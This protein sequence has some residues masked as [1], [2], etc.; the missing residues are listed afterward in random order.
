MSSLS[1]VVFLGACLIVAAFQ[2]AA[3][4]DGPQIVEVDEAGPPSYAEGGWYLRGDIGYVVAED[5]V[6]T[7]GSGAVTFLNEDLGTTWMIGGGI[8][9]R[10]NSWF[11]TD[12]TFDY[13]TFDFTGNTPCLPACGLSVETYDLETWTIMANVYADLGTWHGVTPY[14]GAGIGAAYHWLH[15]IVGVNP[16][17]V[18]TVVPDGGGWAFAAAL[19]AGAS[20]AVT[21]R[22]LIDA[23]YR[24]IW[25]GDVESGADGSG[26]TVLFEDMAE[27]EFRLGLRVEI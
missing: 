27:H 14:V 4:A 26:G 11:R 23:G 1:R 24:Y 21:E 10:F 3:A 20:V 2:V 9:Y 22:T 19:M 12:L 16:G 13:R 5:P 17:P 6:V 25:L 15:N 7:Y 8:G 18:I